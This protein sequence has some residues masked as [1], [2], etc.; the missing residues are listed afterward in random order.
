MTDARRDSARGR[1]RERVQVRDSTTTR[2]Q[3]PD[4]CE[5]H[6]AFASPACE[7]RQRGPDDATRALRFLSETGTADDFSGLSVN[8]QSERSAGSRSAGLL[9]VQALEVHVRY[10]SG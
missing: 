2:F 4:L 3:G 6:R 10:N 7:S 8:G 1:R 5:L 9:Q